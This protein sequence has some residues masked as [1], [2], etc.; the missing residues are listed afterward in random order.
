MKP[1][2]VLVLEDTGALTESSQR[3]TSDNLKK[4]KI[5]ITSTSIKL[6]YQIWKEIEKYFKLMWAEPDY[7]G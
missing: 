4:S 1:L 7:E 6:S 3:L 2:V 5:G